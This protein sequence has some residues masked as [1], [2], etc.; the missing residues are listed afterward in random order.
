MLK[1]RYASDGSRRQWR[2]LQPRSG[3]ADLAGRYGLGL[4]QLALQ[5]AMD[6]GAIGSS[7]VD[8]R[9]VEVERNADAGRSLVT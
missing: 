4:G 1:C 9:A 3:K 8:E 2:S 7:A 5:S 6:V